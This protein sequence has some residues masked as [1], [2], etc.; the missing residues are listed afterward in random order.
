[1]TIGWAMV[2]SW[3]STCAFGAGT[4]AEDR[5]VVVAKIPNRIVVIFIIFSLLFVL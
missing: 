5:T 3:D 2:I 1:M 4:E